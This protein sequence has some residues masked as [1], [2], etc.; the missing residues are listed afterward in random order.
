MSRHM[1]AQY[2][3][4]YHKRNLIRYS[5]LSNLV[6]FFNLYQVADDEVVYI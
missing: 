4:I 6:V 5:I 2:V 3:H 1:A